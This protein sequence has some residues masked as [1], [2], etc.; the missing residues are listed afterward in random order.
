MT[1][2]LCT[3]ALTTLDSFV[4]GT[5]GSHVWNDG[6]VVAGRSVLNEEF[7]GVVSLLGVAGRLPDLVA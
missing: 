5:I 1:E 4:K 6:T 2:A 7:P 3:T